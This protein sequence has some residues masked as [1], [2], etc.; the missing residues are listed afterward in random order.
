M[1]RIFLLV[2]LL[3]VLTFPLA[4][5]DIENWISVS[6]VCRQGE[7]ILYSVQVSDAITEVALFP[8]MNGGWLWFVGES[9]TRRL[10]IS[11]ENE[12]LA[13]SAFVNG[14]LSERGEV[15][16]DGAPDCERSAAP[17]PQMNECLG[18]SV[19]ELIAST[20]YTPE[21]AVFV[22]DGHEYSFGDNLS[23]FVPIEAVWEWDLYI[24]DRHLLSFAQGE[25][26]ACAITAFYPQE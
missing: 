18:L 14:G 5:Q 26:T 10:W 25:G 9:K 7:S 21:S 8:S 20:G 16:W 3:V 15:L 11:A 23:F 2:L 13:Y 1:R 19:A 17:A 22:V 6:A 24:D 4:G 12:Y